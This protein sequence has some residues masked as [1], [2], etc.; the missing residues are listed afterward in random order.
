MPGSSVETS[1]QV[2]FFSIFFPVG[3][4]LCSVTLPTVSVAMSVGERFILQNR[5]IF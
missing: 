5:K 1:W 4:L 2:N 3:V